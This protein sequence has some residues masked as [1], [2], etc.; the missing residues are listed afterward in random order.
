M[1]LESE[2]EASNNESDG[3]SDSARVPESDHMAEFKP[4]P[5]E[6]AADLWLSGV[7]DVDEESDQEQEDSDEESGEESDST[8]A[9]ESSDIAKSKSALAQVAGDLW[10][11]DVDSDEVSD[12]AIPPKS[13]DS[14]DATYTPAQVA[15]TLW[16]E[17]DNGSQ[18]VD[19]AGDCASDGAD[20]QN[21]NNTGPSW[22][23]ED[24]VVLGVNSIGGDTHLTGSLLDDDI[25]MEEVTS[26]TPS[27]ITLPKCKYTRGDFNLP[28][29]YVIDDP[30][31]DMED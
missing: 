9:L 15:A 3:Q 12:S 6:V 11:A 1:G 10:L 8:M 21:S 23:D 28:S 2:E 25:A 18:E 20:E 5:A 4:T 22:L 31:V 7:D 30:E 27:K 16:L 24:N 29:Y 14:T 17:L 26:I 19:D 13:S